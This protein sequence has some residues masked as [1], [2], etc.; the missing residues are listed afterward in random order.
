M[1]SLK[2]P[3][4]LSRH[5]SCRVKSSL[6]SHRDMVTA[7]LFPSTHVALPKPLQAQDWFR[8][9]LSSSPSPKRKFVS[10]T[11]AGKQSHRSQRSHE[12]HDAGVKLLP[13]CRPIRRSTAARADQPEQQASNAGIRMIRT[14]SVPSP[15]FHCLHITCI[16]SAFTP[17]DS[18]ALALT[19][20]PSP[21]RE[22]RQ[23]RVRAGIFRQPKLQ[24]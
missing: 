15:R 17:P 4:S 3:L 8:A 21:Q 9:V 5:V 22:L 12:C 24:R 19:S 23:S 18:C 16:G 7:V 20:S 2:V 1:V 6:V 10:P 11:H 14:C 13:N